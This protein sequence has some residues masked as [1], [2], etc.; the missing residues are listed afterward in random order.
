MKKNVVDIA[1]IAQTMVYDIQSP[2]T[3]IGGFCA[4]PFAGRL[5]QR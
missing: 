4:A 2:L 3:G 5:D 1:H